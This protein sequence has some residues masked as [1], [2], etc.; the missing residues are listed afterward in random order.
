MK[1]GKRT[2]KFLS[3][4]LVLVLTLS[5]TQIAFA[6]GAATW[7]VSRSKTATELNA[8]NES[9]VT[10]SLPS[11]EEQFDSDIVF[12]MDDSTSA[13]STALE[14]AFSLLNDLKGSEQSSGASINVCVVQFNRKASKSAWFD[15]STQK[16]TSKMLWKIQT[17]AERISMPVSLQEWKH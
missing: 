17:A 7:D 6:D 2:R 1:K 14:Q 12:V 16:K 9:T 15:L 8:N 11:A 3:C 4:I 13:S 10:L 5:F